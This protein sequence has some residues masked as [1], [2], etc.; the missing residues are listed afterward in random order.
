MGDY[1]RVLSLDIS[2]ALATAEDRAAEG[3][4]EAVA[5]P[6]LNG[7]FDPALTH[8]FASIF[9]GGRSTGWV[10]LPRPECAEG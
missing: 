5:W 6:P 8:Y 10:A 3:Y 1:A 4:Q 9:W 7:F 2:R